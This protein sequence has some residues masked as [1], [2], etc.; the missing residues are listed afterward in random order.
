MKKLFITATIVASLFSS[1]A[2]AKT[3]GNY[4]GVDVLRSSS[5]AGTS[6]WTDGS[7]NF[8]SD[9]KIKDS[10][11]ISLG[12]NY[13]Y[14]VN[15]NN[16]FVAPVVFFDYTN[17]SAKDFVG[18]DWKLTARAGARLD[19]GY[20]VTDKIAVFVNAGLANN[21]YDV[22]W[23]SEGA[24]KKDSDL[25]A[26]FGAGV[27]YSILDNMDVGLT[28]EKSEFEMESPVTPGKQLTKFDIDVIKVGAA[29][30]F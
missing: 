15:F 10:D 5:S 13:K 1:I 18:D 21:Y 3:E 14:A 20:D 30:K 22:D 12:V 25:S 28:Y 27:K 26:T 29:F 11:Q 4:V 23:K 17:I 6:K 19:L 7:D 16:F 9:S 24:R 8:I 2:S